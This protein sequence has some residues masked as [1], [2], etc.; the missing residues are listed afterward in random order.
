[1]GFYTGNDLDNLVELI[2]TE[3]ASTLPWPLDKENFIY[4][5]PE[6]IDGAKD[7]E[8]NTKVRVQA[9]SSSKY[10]GSVNVEYRRINLSTLFRGIPIQIYR[11]WTGYTY[12]RDVLPLINE[13]YGLNLKQ[14]FGNGPYWA[15]SQSG[16]P[17]LLTQDKNN[18]FYTGS[19]NVVCYMDKEELGLDALLVKDIDRIEWPGGNVFSTPEGEPVDRRGQGQFLLAGGDFTEYFMEENRSGNQSIYSNSLKEGK[20]IDTIQQLRPDIEL[21]NSHP[22]NGNVSILSPA[23]YNNRVVENDTQQIALDTLNRSKTVLDRNILLDAHGYN[24]LGHFSP[25]SYLVIVNERDPETNE[26]TDFTRVTGDLM[27]KWNSLWP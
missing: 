12:M 19:T 8:A 26:I 15:V 6:S 1:M 20:L 3:N 4:S 21:A 18:Y 27:L 7:S 25:S 13:R 17:K 2:N 9:K 14:D 23:S 24:R 10:R 5:L 11:Y 16:T 22:S